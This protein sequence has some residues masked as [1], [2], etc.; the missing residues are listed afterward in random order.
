MHR[1]SC[2]VGSAVRRSALSGIEPGNPRMV[3][4]PT[5]M[6]PDRGLTLE[7]APHHM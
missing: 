5:A 7:K 6:M 4:Y 1:A 2:V 3:I